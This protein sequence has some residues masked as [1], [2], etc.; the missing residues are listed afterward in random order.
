MQIII[1]CDIAASRVLQ[2]ASTQRL[3]PTDRGW[4]SC[5]ATVTLSSLPHLSPTHSQRSRRTGSDRGRKKRRS[6][7]IC[8]R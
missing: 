3:D 6:F 1:T 7:T 2:V 4:E 8:S 5:H